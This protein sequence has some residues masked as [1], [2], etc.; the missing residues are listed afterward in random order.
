MRKA[1]L[2]VQI[3]SCLTGISVYGIFTIPHNYINLFTT[4]AKIM[5]NTVTIRYDTII[6]LVSFNAV[7]LQFL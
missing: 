6:Q 3:R 2:H 4:P 5:Y 1:L 7:F